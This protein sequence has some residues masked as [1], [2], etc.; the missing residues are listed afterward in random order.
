MQATVLQN[1][2][3]KPGTRTQAGYGCTAR[4]RDTTMV[5]GSLHL[6]RGVLQEAVHIAGGDE[7]LHDLS[8]VEVTQLDEIIETLQPMSTVAGQCISRSTECA[9]RF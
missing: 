7:D 2:V 6:H 8:D 1:N 9:W 3:T 4:V 5:N